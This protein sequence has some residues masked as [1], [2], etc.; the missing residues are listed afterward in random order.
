MKK[1]IRVAV[2]GELPTACDY[3][4]QNGVVSI[5]RFSCATDIGRETDYHL[6]L[7]YAP[8]GEG[9]LDVTFNGSEGQNNQ[10]PIRLLNEPCCDSALIELK[11][12]IRRI[13]DRMQQN[14]NCV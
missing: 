1:N 2:C 9:L 3:L 13:E 10:V 14:I 5:D 4:L 6:I 12:I 7:V 8:H 11:S